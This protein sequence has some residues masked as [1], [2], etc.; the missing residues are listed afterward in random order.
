MIMWGLYSATPL[1]AILL[2][3]AITCILLIPFGMFVGAYAVSALCGMGPFI[4]YH[5][6]PVRERVD[7]SEEESLDSAAGSQDI[8]ATASFCLDASFSEILRRLATFSAVAALGSFGASV[9]YATRRRTREEL[10]SGTQSSLTAADEEPV[11]EMTL[12]LITVQFVG[13]SFAVALSL[14]FFGGLVGGSLFP[15]GGPG[16]ILGTSGEREFYKLLT[17]SF[18]A[19]FMQRTVPDF[20][21]NLV[22]R[23]KAAQKDS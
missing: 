18:I 7:S 2:S 15:S 21:T 11:V 4:G 16:N 10:R 8:A 23:S 3:L 13:A 1:R 20:L 22:K 19:G 5:Q 9:G 17:W 6:S 12:E 14:L